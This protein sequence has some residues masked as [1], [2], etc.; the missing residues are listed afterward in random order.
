MAEKKKELTVEES[1]SALDSMVKQLESPDISLEDS[2]RIY[3][4]GMKLLKEVNGKID[5]VEKKLQKIDDS[6]KTE[7]FE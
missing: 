5:L 6:G 2:F 4:D 3:E 7:E 1:F